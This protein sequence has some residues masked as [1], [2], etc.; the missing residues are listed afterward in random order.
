MS[1]K[2]ANAILISAAS[3]AALYFLMD[4]KNT[5][6]PKPTSNSTNTSSSQNNLNIKGVTDFVNKLLPYA[7]AAYK[8]TGMP[9]IV[10]MIFAAIESGYGKHAPQ[11]NF[12]GIKAGTQWKGLTQLLKTFE[13][14]KTGNPK[15]DRISDKLISI[16]APNSTGSHAACNKKG[17]YTYRVYGKFRAYSSPAAAFADF[18]NFIKVNKRYAAAWKYTNNPEQMGIEILK[19]GYATA[20]SY[21]EAYR[22]IYKGMVKLMA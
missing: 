22:K 10:V 12:F 11:N 6:T 5:T 8:I 4:L 7:K 19:A 13:C 1:N 17:K 16:H 18:G 3:V 20:P 15:T 9:P 21:Q 2:K 14:G